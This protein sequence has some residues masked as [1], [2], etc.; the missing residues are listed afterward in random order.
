MS[1]ILRV[2]IGDMVGEARDITSLAH[3]LHTALAEG[4]NDGKGYIGTAS[5]LSDMLFDFANRLEE[6]SC[7]K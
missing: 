4:K 5:I 6:L 1:E 2:E 7:Q 3:T